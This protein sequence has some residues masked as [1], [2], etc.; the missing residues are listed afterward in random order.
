MVDTTTKPFAWSYSKLKN[1]E[2]CGK[3]HYEVDISKNYKEDAS[4]HLAWG[5][6]VHK[7]LANRI[8]MGKSLPKGMEK[9]EKWVEMIVTPPGN[10]LIEQKFAITADF[11]PCEYFAKEVWYRG[12]ADVLKLNDTVA[13][14][15]DW[16]TGKILDDT[17]QLALMAACVFIHHPEVQDVRTEFIWLKY[18]NATSREDFKRSDM[19]QMWKSQWHRIEALQHAYKTMTFPA[20]P[21]FLCKRWCPVDNCPH[22]GT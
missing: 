3:R 21:G 7:A 18:D 22:H 10:V 2:A 8:S 4:E 6:S 5:N 20:R 14:A 1:F 9:F 17:V 13:L 16:K 11:S 12:I 15:V 19:V